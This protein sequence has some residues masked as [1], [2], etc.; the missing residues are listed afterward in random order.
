MVFCDNLASIEFYYRLSADILPLKLISTVAFCDIFNPATLTLSVRP[1]PSRGK[2]N[3]AFL[4]LYR[5]SSSF[6]Q[7][8]ARIM[9]IMSVSP[10][11]ICLVQKIGAFCILPAAGGDF[12]AQ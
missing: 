10:F 4:S 6:D 2:P 11:L 5:A 7:A 3:K 12:T 1:Y 8:L 9:L